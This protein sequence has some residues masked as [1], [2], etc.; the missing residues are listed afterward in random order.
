MVR[1]VRYTR[2][3]RRHV[4]N[5][6]FYLTIP[7][8]TH[9]IAYI[10]VWQSVA[11]QRRSGQS[12]QREISVLECYY[13]SKIKKFRF[14]GVL[15]PSGRP[16]V[17]PSALGPLPIDSASNFRLEML[18]HGPTIAKFGFWGCW[19]PSGRPGVGPMASGP[20]PI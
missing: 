18:L 10:C 17:G 14:L 12:I 16:G 2:R 19:P 11:T 8:N 9:T 5:L 15:A 13:Y 6:Y 1:Y 7:Y 20:L 4:P 3:R